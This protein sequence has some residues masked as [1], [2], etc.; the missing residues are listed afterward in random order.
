MDIEV[1]VGQRLRYQ[2]AE[3]RVAVI[4]EKKVFFD[5]GRWGFVDGLHDS[6]CE[7]LPSRENEYVQG[8]RLSF[9]SDGKLDSDCVY[10]CELPSGSSDRHVVE[11][12][13]GMRWI[14]Q[15][16]N[17]RRQ[18]PAK[19]MKW[20]VPTQADIDAATEPISCL[21]RD[22]DCEEWKHDDL[23][24][25]S[26]FGQNRFVDAI[27]RWKYCLIQVPANDP[28]EAVEVKS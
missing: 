19:L 3:C 17:L 5:N 10:V 18:E 4:C 26:K 1:K 2:G 12:D 15:N 7:L 13:G 20:V 28:R 23:V 24:G 16:K 14:A 22:R 21:V 6:A 9:I 25:I 27:Y 8:E 11:F